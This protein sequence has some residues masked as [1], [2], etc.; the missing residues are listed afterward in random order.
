MIKGKIRTIP[1]YPKPGISFRDITPLLKDAMAFN[2]AIDALAEKISEKDFDYIAGIEARGF[3]IGSALS[4]KLRKGFIPIRKKGKLPYEKIGIDYEL[5]YG[6]E[7]LEVHKDAAE[8]GSK[9]LIVDDLLAT[10]GTAKAA[11]QLITKIGA[12]VYG[13]AF[14][15]ELSSLDGRKKLGEGRIIYLVAY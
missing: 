4:Y 11:A 5:E 8:K 9:V 6:K 3:I 10:G 1:N 12:K 14:V 15:V 7:T 2:L 13:Y